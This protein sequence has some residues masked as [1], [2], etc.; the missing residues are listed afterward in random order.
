M[1]FD[2]SAG[3]GDEPRAGIEQR[4]LSGS[5]RADEAGD[6]ADGGRQA[7]PLQRPV[8]SVTDGQILDDES[9]A[10]DG[11]PCG[12]S[13][14]FTGLAARRHAPRSAARAKRVARLGRSP[15][16]ATV[17]ASAAVPKMAGPQEPNRPGR[18][19]GTT[20]R[21]TAARMAGLA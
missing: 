6:P 18:Y 3:H 7:H 11:D 1:E 2:A 21:P 12:R 10:H 16:P 19:D 15:P 20:A 17:T 9:S 4:G 8:P 14:A 13:L 5:V